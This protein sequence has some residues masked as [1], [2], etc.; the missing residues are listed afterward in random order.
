MEQSP[1]WGANQLS[2]QE[3]PLILHKTSLGFFFSTHGG[4]LVHGVQE[5]N[6]KM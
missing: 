2:S 6:S 5:S 1:S 3:I 4:H